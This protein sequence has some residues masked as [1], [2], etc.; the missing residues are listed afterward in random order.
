MSGRYDN[1][2]I[3]EQTRKDMTLT[4]DDLIVIKRL[5]DLQDGAFEQ[6]MENLAK[7][8]LDSIDKQTKLIQK[9]MKDV[10]NIK[11][12]VSDIKK[13]QEDHEKRIR[14]LEDKFDKM[15]A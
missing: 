13:K 15:I 2:P 7:Q 9:I 10:A 11:K 8:F 1:I 12:D 6:M 3:S 5:F 14:C 4:I